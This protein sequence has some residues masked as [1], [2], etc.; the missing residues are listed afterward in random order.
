MNFQT[1][2]EAPERTND[3]YRTNLARLQHVKAA[4]DPHNV[5]HIN[6]NIQPSQ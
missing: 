3:S 6:R 5:F 4:Y 2:D 1:A